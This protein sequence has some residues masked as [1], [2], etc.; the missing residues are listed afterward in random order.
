MAEGPS[1][2]LVLAGDHSKTLDAA[3]ST[4]SCELLQY[5][6]LLNQAHKKSHSSLPAWWTLKSYNIVAEVKS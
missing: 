6:L 5:G 4:L 3:Y 2:L 1:F